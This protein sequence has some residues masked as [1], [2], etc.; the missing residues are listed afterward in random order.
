[1]QQY[2]AASKTAKFVS[3]H[4][5]AGSRYSLLAGRQIDQQAVEE[6]IHDQNMLLIALLGGVE[7]IKFD[8]AAGFASVA[9]GGGEHNSEASE[10]QQQQ[11]WIEPERNTGTPPSVA[12]LQSSALVGA[13]ACAAS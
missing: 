4:T 12:D 1:M 10:Q 7:L 5:S 3:F 13:G 6:V 2:V 11:L 9:V 8:T